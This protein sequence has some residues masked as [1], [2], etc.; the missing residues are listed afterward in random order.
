VTPNYV[1]VVVIW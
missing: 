1:L